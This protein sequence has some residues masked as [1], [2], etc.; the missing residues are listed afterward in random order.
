M[1]EIVKKMSESEFGE[2]LS[3][4]GD[5]GKKQILENFRKM[6]KLCQ[7]VAYN[8]N[9][10]PSLFYALIFGIETQAAGGCIKK[11]NSVTG[12]ILGKKGVKIESKTI[13]PTKP[14]QIKGKEFRVDVENTNPG[15]KPASVHIQ[16]N[17]IPNSPKYYFNPS[18]KKLYEKIGDGFAESGNAVQ[19]LLKSQEI[20]KR[21]NKALETV[22][23]PATNF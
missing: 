20:Q 4:V 12:E 21:I 11:I 13:N 23:E 7:L 17:K 16:I 22:S 14:I 19:D 9:R 1:A 8:S 2:F 18:D 15:V 3:K 10:Q 6:A 5:S